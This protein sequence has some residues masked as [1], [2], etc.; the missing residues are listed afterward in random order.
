M[1]IVTLFVFLSSALAG[2]MASPD[3]PQIDVASAALADWAGEAPIVVK[4]T[5]VFVEVEAVG[6]RAL[7]SEVMLRIDA[8][9]RDD[10]ALVA[11]G[12]II[13]LR[14]PGGELETW[15]QLTSD[16]PV[17]V[18]GAE[19]LVTLD[20][21]P[22]GLWPAHGNR[23]FLPLV[24]DALRFCAAPE[25]SAMSACVADEEWVLPVTGIRPLPAAA[26]LQVVSAQDIG[27]LSL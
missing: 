21:R 20:L 26:T 15:G 7:E 4:V 8:V 6:P 17:F 1:P 14:L 25:A 27:R 11:E 24:G 5:A 9:L 16:A 3:L 13:E 2:P 22:D 10:E 18:E 23:S 12:E 19:G